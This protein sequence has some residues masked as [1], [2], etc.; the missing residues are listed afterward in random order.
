MP[1]AAESSPM[2]IVPARARRAP[3]QVT[4]AMSAR[5]RLAL[6]PCTHESA[7]ATPYPAS[8]RSAEAAR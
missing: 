5:G 6:R 2:V 3:T 4:T 1:K 8:R 7:V